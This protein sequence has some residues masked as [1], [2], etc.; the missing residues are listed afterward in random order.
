MVRRIKCGPGIS[1]DLPILPAH[2]SS[3]KKARLPGGLRGLKV[4]RPESKTT[5]LIRDTAAA[6]D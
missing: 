5:F 4:E 6:R 3:R 2:G 1:A